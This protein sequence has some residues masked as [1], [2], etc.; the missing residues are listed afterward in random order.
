M[1]GIPNFIKYQIFDTVDKAYKKKDI[2]IAL[3]YDYH[4]IKFYVNFL[5]GRADFTIKKDEVILEQVTGDHKRETMDIAAANRSLYIDLVHKEIVP[6]LPD[7][8]QICEWYT[9]PA[10]RKFIIGAH[11]YR[12]GCIKQKDT[13]TKPVEF[14]F[15]IRQVPFERVTEFKLNDITIDNQTKE[16]DIYN[17]TTALLYKYGV[18]NLAKLKKIRQKFQ[19]KLSR[20]DYR[21]QRNK[22]R[23][24]LLLHKELRNHIEQRKLSENRTKADESF[25]SPLWE[26][27]Q[28][29]R[30]LR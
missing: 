20:A 4:K 27:I 24:K 9:I 15:D 28:P 2:P 3:S 22:T 13:R 19:L 30:L 6:I 11:I 5:R 10:R 16:E 29:T 21:R 8:H 23:F 7:A 25:L 14:S 1:D 18:L 17:T 12:P 26:E